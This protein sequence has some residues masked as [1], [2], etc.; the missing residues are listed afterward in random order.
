MRFLVLCILLPL[1]LVSLWGQSNRD[2]T[3]TIDS[4]AFGKERK[5]Y[6]HLPERYEKNPLDTFSVVFALDAQS[7]Q[8]WNMAKHNVAY[9][10]NTYQTL[11]L[12]VVGIHSDSRQW[13]F[14]PLPEDPKAERN[15]KAQAH[16][17]HQHLR[18]EVIP[19]LEET[20]RINQERI[21]VGHSRG[22]AFI[23]ETLFSQQRDLFRAYLAI[24]PA[25]GHV[26]NQMLYHADAQLKHGT[27][28][29]KYLYC[30]HGTVGNYEADFSNHVDYLDSLI[31]EHQ[32]KSLVFEREILAGTDH[33]S[34]VIPSW[35][36]GL[37]RM[38]RQF[39][40]DLSHL[41][42]FAKNQD[43]SVREQ[44]EEFYVAAERRYGFIRF[45]DVRSLSFYANEFAEAGHRGLAQEVLGWG[46]SL[47]P[48]SVR[49]LRNMGYLHR[50]HQEFA[51]A[52][53]W[54]ELALQKLELQR[55]H[56]DEREYLEDK[57]NLE[58]NIRRAEAAK[59]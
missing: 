31:T 24:S 46:I 52:K 16:L 8:Y 42:A 26:N 34:V 13:E 12:I 43:R 57:A 14:I 38:S 59:E 1:G 19:L 18:E 50:T 41:E 17:L 15:R 22:G 20:Y 39:M 23:A 25:L 56:I 35:N 36:N 44:A 6:I 4:E 3:H 5:I 27:D 2:V 9:L 30:S 55:D 37:V 32:N 53:Y 10:V 40:V 54:Y 21:L 11:P 29:R 47:Y 51:E 7:G 28:F 45:P 58:R 48:N 33:W 49:L